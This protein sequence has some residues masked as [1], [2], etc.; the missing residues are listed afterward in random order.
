[1][2]L[3]NDD[4]SSELK[5]TSSVMRKILAEEPKNYVLKVIINQ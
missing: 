2:L 1:M 5:K 4:I 3:G